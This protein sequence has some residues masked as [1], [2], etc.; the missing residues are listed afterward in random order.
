[1]SAV[2]ENNLGS[3]TYSDDYIASIAGMATTECYGVVGMASSCW[4]KRTSSGALRYLRTRPTSFGLI[5]ISSC[6]MGLQFPPH[7]TAL[8]RRSAIR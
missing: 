3:I 4:A 1:M 7:R 5:C 6:N 8:L 2:L